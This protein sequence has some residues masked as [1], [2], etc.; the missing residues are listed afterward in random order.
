MSVIPEALLLAKHEATAMHDVTRGGLLETLLEISLLS[1]VSI[2]VDASRLPILPVVTRFAQA[3]TFDPL[4]MISSGTLAATVPTN[5]VAKAMDALNDVG[6]LSAD[7]GQVTE[8]AGV[9][10]L[11]KGET[12]RYHTI[13]CEEDELARMWNLY[14]RNE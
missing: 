1:G 13:R 2:E 3:F 14:P 11:R 8:G 6:V 12:V 5:S 9:S 4:R 7:V 10:I